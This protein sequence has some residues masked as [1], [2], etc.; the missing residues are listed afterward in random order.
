MAI[1]ATAVWEVRGGAGSDSNGGLYVAALGGT[2]LSQ[3][4]T[5]RA[6]S[7]DGH[8]T[9]A[10]GTVTSATIGFLATDVGNGL[11]IGGTI[12]EI[13]AYTSATQVTITPVFAG[14]TTTTGA[15]AIG[16][17]LATPT[18]AIA[19]CV[20]QNTIWVKAATYQVSSAPVTLP[21]GVVGAYTA[22]Q[23][24]NTTRG[25]LVYGSGLTM[26]LIQATGG[27][28]N[29]LAETNSFVMISG[30]TIDANAM[31]TTG[32]VAS[33][34]VNLVLSN[35]VL[36]G[37]TTWGVNYSNSNASAVLMNCDISSSGNTP[38]QGGVY[39]QGTSLSIINC[40]IH[41]M[42]APGVLCAGTTSINVDHSI[43]ANCTGASS[44]GLS[45]AASTPIA[46]TNTDVY[47]SGR[48]GIRLTTAGSEG[49]IVVQNCIL[50][51]NGGW[52]MKLTTTRSTT[53]NLDF[54][55][56]GS[57]TSGPTT[58]ITGTLP[59]SQTLSVSPWRSVGQR[60]RDGYVGLSA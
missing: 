36:K 45:L 3:S 26:P 21:A 19:S 20:G 5:A 9:N 6:T 11:N 30:F 39:L 12:Y 14:T 55:A 1:A 23:G 28:T 4:N 38:S 50:Y 29:I 32:C 33:S 54:N 53:P 44:D 37:F 60:R 34:T 51:G 31:A 35:C 58:G 22:L 13:S 10:S 41:D 59:F 18:K 56:Y 42:A 49:G 57:N 15:L 24:Y 17:A 16:G 43:I 2:D 7:A 47:G 27:M 40:Y 48:D 46:V 25:D 52:G 8:A